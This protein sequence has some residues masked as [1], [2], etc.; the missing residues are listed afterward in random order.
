MPECQGDFAMSWWLHQVWHAGD[1]HERKR[2]G[3]SLVRTGP[4]IW[5]LAW[6]WVGHACPPCQIWPPPQRTAATAVW[7]TGILLGLEGKS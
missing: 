7:W 2:R 1:M 3:T 4:L 6:L 5:Y